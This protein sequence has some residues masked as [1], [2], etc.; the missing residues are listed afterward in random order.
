MSKIPTTP[1]IKP[2]AVTFQPSAAAARNAARAERKRWRV[3]VSAKGLKSVD[4]AIYKK[5]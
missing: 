5:L 3:R 4:V 1:I 2:E